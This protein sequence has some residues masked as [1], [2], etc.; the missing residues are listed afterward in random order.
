MT[1]FL[2]L[3]IVLA[4]I[5]IVAKVAGSLSQRIGQPSVFGELLIGLVLGPTVLNFMGFFPAAHELEPVLKDMA[6]L[7]VILLMFLAGLE[8]DLKAMRKVGMAAFVGASGGVVLPFIFGIL[9]SLP[10]GFPIKEAVFIGTVLTATSVSISAQTLIELGQI[11]S[12]EGVTILGA[13]V[14]DDVMG[15]VVLSLVVALLGNQA[16]TTTT[17]S[18]VVA[19]AWI[20]AKM[21]IYFGAAIL[22]GKFLGPILDWV[23]AKMKSTESLAA[24]TLGIMFLY[25]WGAEYLGGVA[26]I[27]GSYILGVLIAQT[28]LGHQ[29]E[30]K[31]RVPTY[32]LLVP[33]FFIHIGLQADARTLIG[34]DFTY[35]LII[36]G[37]AVVAKMVGAALGV[38]CTGFR[39]AESMRVGIGMISRGEVALIV[40]QVGLTAGVIEERVF[41]IMVI[42]T[43][44]TTLV[45]PP[46]LRLVFPK[47]SE[48]ATSQA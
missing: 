8:T 18:P 48:P 13:A 40:T 24:I 16:A 33:I 46:L 47:N 45:T 36:V 44:V 6:E 7:G 43:L 25:A 32:A 2:Q 4:V 23:L 35:T 12:K 10:F 38:L 34:P 37:V 42:M 26:A 22:I 30:E 20:V 28:H 5:V 41:S 29:I 1:P 14:I 31:L 9:V 3:L 27:T 15:I 11:K 19:V 21:I 39:F 17:A